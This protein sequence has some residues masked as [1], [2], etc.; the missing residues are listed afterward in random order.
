[1]RRKVYYVVILIFVI[2]IGLLLLPSPAS[3]VSYALDG[4]HWYLSRVGLKYDNLDPAWRDVV[5]NSRITWDF[6]SLT[7]S[8][9]GIYITY[10]PY[11]SNDVTVLNFQIPNFVGLT[12]KH[13]Y[14]NGHWLIDAKV[15][16]NLYYPVVPYTPAYNQIDGQSVVTHELGHVVGLNEYDAEPAVMNS[17]IGYGVVKRNLYPSDNYGLF[18]LYPPIFRLYNGVDHFYTQ[19]A[20][21]RDTLI[22]WG[23]SYEGVRFYAWGGVIDGTG[24]FYRLYN[25]T[26]HFYT[27]DPNERDYAMSVGYAYEGIATYVLSYPGDSDART[28]YRLYNGR[29]HFYTIDPSERDYA[30]SV[31]YPYEGIRAYV[32][33]R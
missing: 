13:Y 10:D 20:S 7:N 22:S 24:P 17:T 31:G 6:A 11:S 15:S 14:V 21:E 8:Y 1:M 23:W 18:A 9:A 33:Y 32:R 25:G 16:V 5:Y 12:S 26:D 19:S 27:A 29:D 30:I 3:A 4:T 2:M 28:L